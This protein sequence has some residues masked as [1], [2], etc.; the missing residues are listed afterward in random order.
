MQFVYA[1]ICF[2]FSN[3]KMEY[4][5]FLTLPIIMNFKK[6]VSNIPYGL[7]KKPWTIVFLIEKQNP[8]LLYFCFS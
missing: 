8:Q 3:G 1:N 2:V 4:H 6:Y 7:V 5:N